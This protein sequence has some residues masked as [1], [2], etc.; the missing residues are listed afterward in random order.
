MCYTIMRS[1]WMQFCIT[2]LKNLRNF[3]F[4]VSLYAIELDFLLTQTYYIDNYKLKG[5]FI[6]LQKV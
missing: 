5:L 1:R 4:N 2:Q 6:E 3:L